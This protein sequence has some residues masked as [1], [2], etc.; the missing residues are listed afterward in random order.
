MFLPVVVLSFHYL[1]WKVILIKWNN[2]I[3]GQTGCNHIPNLLNANPKIKKIHIIVNYTKMSPF[4]VCLP[5][6]EY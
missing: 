4:F 6:K 2:Y 3:S 1:F 5:I